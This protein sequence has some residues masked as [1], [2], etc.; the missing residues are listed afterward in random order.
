MSEERRRK[1]SLLGVVAYVLVPGER[2]VRA[3][4]HFRKAGLETLM[5]FGEFVRP[6]KRQDSSG[7][8]GRERIQID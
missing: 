3:A 4:S 2:R 1:G 7:S 8:S 5:G 6:D